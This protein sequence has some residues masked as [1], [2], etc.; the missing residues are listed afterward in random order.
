VQAVMEKFHGRN[1]REIVK[2]IGFRQE[3]SSRLLLFYQ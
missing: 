2:K 3:I 1:G